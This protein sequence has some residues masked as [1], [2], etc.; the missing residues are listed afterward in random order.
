MLEDFV[1][2]DAWRTGVRAYIARH[3]L[4]NTQSVDLWR[5]IQQAAGR[6]V[7]DIAHQFTTQ[8]GVPLVRV[9]SAQC[10]GGSTQVTL[11]QGQFSRDNRDG[12]PLGWRVPIIA[13]AGRAPLR[14]LVDGNTRASVPG[15]GPLVVNYGQAGYYRTLYSPALFASLT[16]N[17]ARLRPLDQIGL[18]A[19]NWALGLAGYQDAGRGARPRRGDARRRQCEAPDPDRR[20]PRPGERDVPRGSGAPGDARS[21]RL[22]KARP[23]DAPSRLGPRAQ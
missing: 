2:E 1:G 7:T 6:P 3:R 22:G 8:P 23:G 5:A 17:F 10:S 11:S 16:R 18:I 9:E 15:C 4:G 14:T 13:H 20:D 12:A 19:D 21:P